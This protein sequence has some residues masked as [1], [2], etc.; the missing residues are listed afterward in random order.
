MSVL[1]L[2]AL[3]ATAT[4]PVP[5]APPAAE[6]AVVQGVRASGGPSAYA[7]AVTVKSPDRDCSRYASWWE[8]VTPEG[9]LVYRR[10]L[11]HSHKDEQPFTRSGGPVAIQPDQEVIVRAHLHPAGYGTRGMRGTVAGGFEAVTMPGDWAAALSATGPQPGG[12]WY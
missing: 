12:C 8:V 11:A 4:S 3:L 5:K 7:F 9:E 2:A 6:E 1:L 10:I